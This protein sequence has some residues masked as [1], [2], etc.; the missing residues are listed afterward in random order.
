MFFTK[1][2]KINKSQA[3]AIVIDLINL[4]SIKI[5]SKSTMIKALDIF[6]FRNMDFVDCILCA[7]SKVTN[8]SVLTFDKGLKK[9]LENK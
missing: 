4:D 6:A 9:C 7:T 1:I 2:Y 8:N 5:D 3:A